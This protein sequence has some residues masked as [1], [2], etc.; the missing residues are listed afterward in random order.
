MI[1][2]LVPLLLAFLLSLGDR[3]TG[4]IQSAAAGAVAITADTEAIQ[5]TFQDR[6]VLRYLLQKPKDSPSTS[7]SAGYFHPLTTPSGVVVTDVGPDDHLHHRGV[8]LAWLEVRDATEKGDF[9]GWGEHAPV[10]DRRIVHRD[11]DQ[12]VATK[13]S[14]AFRVRNEWLAGSTPLLEETLRATV[15]FRPDARIHDL[16]YRLRSRTEVTLG[17]HAFSGFS[18]RLRKDAPLTAHDPAGPVTLPAPFYLKPESDWPDR[19]WYAFEMALP[20]GKKAGVAVLNHPQN[21]PT[22]WHNVTDIALL[23]PCIIAPGPLR[24]SAAQPLTLRY[25][26]V[27]FDGPVPTPLLNHLAEEFVRAPIPAGR[28]GTP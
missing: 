24:L 10:A 18:V 9:W 25:R 5:V 13:D 7:P 4:A 23:N 19:P 2:R 12:V 17:Q 27:T 16:A 11:T 14:A 15:L 8:F 6:A 26:V 21:P 1:P 28:D 20:E 3:A 22:L